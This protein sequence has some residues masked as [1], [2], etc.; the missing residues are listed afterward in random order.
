M[1]EVVSGWVGAGGRSSPP[2]QLQQ[3]TR[4]PPGSTALL[5][6]T[7]PPN[8]P[9][10]TH[11]LQPRRRPFPAW[12]G[13]ACSGLGSARRQLDALFVGH[14]NP[15]VHPPGG[16]GPGVFDAQG[17]IL[18]GAG[19]RP[20]RALLSF[21]LSWELAELPRGSGTTWRAHVG[22][23][24]SRGIPLSYSGSP[25]K[26]RGSASS[27]D[28][29]SLFRSQ[30]K[31]LAPAFSTLKM[32]RREGGFGAGGLSQ[33]GHLGWGQG[34]PGREA[35]SGVSP[36][37]GKCLCRTRKTSPRA[38]RALQPSPRELCF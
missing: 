1:T 22:K 34:Q 2:P 27:R 10:P 25:Q 24:R 9:A 4:T 8:S 23:E 30:E 5:T 36:S 37:V 3:G 33:G 17:G 18:E 6:R 12:L 16:R 20:P 32:T 15:Q 14:R 21:V 35:R 26:P 38:S 11:R 19:G 28:P 7:S 31:P 29:L 13:V